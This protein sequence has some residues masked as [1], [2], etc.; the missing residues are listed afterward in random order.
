MLAPGPCSARVPKAMSVI[1]LAASDQGRHL[2]LSAE[3]VV[4]VRLEE[5]PTT[6]FR[7]RIRPGTG[8]GLV[9]CGDDFVPVG[10]GAIGAGGE[11]L[12]SFRLEH[13]DPERLGPVRLE[14]EL[15]QAWQAQDRRASF[16]ITLERRP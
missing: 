6:G 12:L 5:N 3:D 2:V 14:L 8:A 7:W 10:G 16:E 4:R 9:P 13:P 11:R 1:Q 15:V